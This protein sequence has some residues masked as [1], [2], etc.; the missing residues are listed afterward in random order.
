MRLVS[1]AV[2]G[3]LIACSNA[4][5]AQD[6]PPTLWEMGESCLLRFSPMADRE[7]PEAASARSGSFLVSRRNP[8]S[9]L[10]TDD[11][12]AGRT[13]PARP[14]RNDPSRGSLPFEASTSEQTRE[15]GTPSLWTSTSASGKGSA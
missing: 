2:V 15:V 6:A 13:L 4:A 14:T 1:V 12:P 7:L 8:G 9:S 10:Q 3:V 5:S 11:P